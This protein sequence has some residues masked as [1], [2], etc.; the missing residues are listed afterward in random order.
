MTTTNPQDLVPT[1]APRRRRW[2]RSIGG[3]IVLLCTSGLAFGLGAWL[4]LQVAVRSPEIDTPQ[5]I[6]VEQAVA[7]QSLRSIGLLP[8]RLATRHDPKLA[9]GVVI[10]QF[11]AGGTRTKRGR[12]VRL[13]ISL[14]PQL[15]SVPS[16]TGTGLQHAQ[17]ELQNLG[18]SLTKSQAYD[19]RIPRGDVVAQ[20][21]PSGSSNVGSEGVRVLVSVG[22]RPRAAVMPEIIGRAA[23]EASTWLQRHGFTRVTVDAT[24]PDP[25]MEN[26]VTRQSPAPGERVLFTQTVSLQT[27]ER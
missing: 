3:V 24:T 9:A 2:L 7:E 12:P 1:R 11:P 5:L 18:L 22:P 26:V 13:I 20:D 17:L 23:G 8:E 25:L 15:A 27:K 6:G 4:T 21:P 10:D 16:L 19:P 14:G